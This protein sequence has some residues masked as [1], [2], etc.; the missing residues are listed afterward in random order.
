MTTETSRDV[1]E[2]T[3]NKLREI[4]LEGV[5]AGAS[6]AQPGRTPYGIGTPAFELWLAGWT[7]A[8]ASAH[9]SG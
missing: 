7:W 3:I 2:Q 4:Y 5:D 8:K 9:A 1:R 6:S